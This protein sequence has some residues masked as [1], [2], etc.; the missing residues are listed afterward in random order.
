MPRPAWVRVLSAMLPPAVRRD[1]FEP[2]LRDLEVQSLHAGRRALPAIAVV[3][4]FLDCWRLAPAEVLAMLLLDVRHAFR[5]LRREVGFTAVAVLTLTLG[6]GANVAVFAVVNA[7]LLRPLPYPEPDRLVLLEHRD[8]RT[9]VTKEFIAI[10][11]FVDL[12]A[13]QRSF[14]SLA[15]YGRNRV[16]IFANPEPFDA[17]AL[18][19][20]VGLLETLRFSPVL[21]PGFG[22]V[23]A[24]DGTASVAILGFDAWQTRF[25]GDPSVIGRAIKFGST[26]RQIVGIAPRGFRFPLNAQTD[27]ILPMTVPLRA[28]AQ[29][30]S[31]WTFAA[32][33]LKPNVSLERARADLTALSQ[34]MEQEYPTQN[35]GSE[36]F[37][38]PLREALVGDTKPALLMLL[39]AVALVL[40]MACANVASL[41][42]ARSLGRRQEM[43][44]RVALGAGRRRLVVQLM[45]ESLV[46]ASVSGAAAVLFARWTIPALASLVPASLNLPQL[47]N[48][49][50]DGRVVGFTG[51]LVL[52]T[53]V[54]F[55]LFSA[56]G[57]RIDRMLESLVSPGRVTSGTAARR[58]TST[59][60]VV[61]IALTI[62]LLT[63]AGLV[64]RSFA[65]LLAVDP[66]FKTA[67]VLTLDIE[68]PADR[69]GPVGAR[70]AFYRRAFEAIGHLPGVEAAGV[71]AVTPLTGNN[72]TVGFERPERPVTPGERPPE[73]GWQS[74]SGGY[75]RALQ[76]PLRA[77]RLFSGQDSPS[78]KPVVIVSEAIQRKYFDGEPAVGHT[79]KAG[80][81]TAEIVGVVGDI[82]RAT[83]TEEPRADMYF[84]MEQEPQNA[85]TL[86]VRSA[87]PPLDLVAPLRA[88]LRS[89]EPSVV[90]RDIRTF[91]S[92]AR[93]SVQI[94]RLALWLLGLFAVTALSLAAVGIYGVMSY[95]VKQRT[96]EIGTRVALGATPRTILWLV[97][98]QGVR[99]AALGTFIGLDI[100]WIAGRSVRGLLY[101]TSPA[102]PAIL[103]GAAGLLLGTALVACYQP[104]RRATRVDPVKTLSSM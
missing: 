87:G 76:I 51:A 62:V 6:V 66:G 46:L 64:L 78:S 57:I 84:P 31:D 61:E 82:R 69:Y 47:A 104:A 49:S 67:H 59:L 12:R 91:D 42:V 19:A 24:T 37:V 22:S 45:V 75:F 3:F 1:L 86:F 2:S 95:S 43:A 103:I 68:V 26:T 94:T 80:L 28:P 72:W 70:Q 20:S 34:Q 23:D 55:S 56:F 96:R 8:R 71:A 93:E 11:D 7:V 81:V 17:A 5:L 40:L 99:I 60:V 30:K 36:Y 14:E 53:A 73:V 16:V 50:L 89:I 88:V 79:V 83:L 100:A 27:V 13:R 38:L 15:G 90:L 85:T 32:A 25:A 98:G 102:D 52:L 48:V 44:I 101:G 63:G 41:L 65:N 33:R 10:G 39:A 9:G 18:V 97:L 21:G 4:L 74:A 77:G 29:R 35:Q 54:A 58:A 92:V